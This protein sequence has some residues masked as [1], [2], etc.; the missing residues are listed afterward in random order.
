MPGPKILERPRLACS[1]LLLLPL[2]SVPLQIFALQMS[3]ARWLHLIRNQEFFIDPWG[4]LGWFKE[5]PVPTRQ[6]WKWDCE[7]SGGI[8]IGSVVTPR[9]CLQWPTFHPKLLWWG[10]RRTDRKKYTTL[11]KLLR[12]QGFEPSYEAAAP[13]TR[14]L[15][16]PT[17][18][19]EVKSSLSGRM[20]DLYESFIYFFIIPWLIPCFQGVV[21][22]FSRSIFKLF[23]LPLI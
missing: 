14:L 17:D 10:L 1:L 22:A 3:A 5:R 15:C 11:C 6:A 8:A 18:I 16:Q 7:S 13:S 2:L 4:K 19:K 12:L 20:K 23:L 9:R 21:Q